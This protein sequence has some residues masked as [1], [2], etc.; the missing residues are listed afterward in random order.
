MGPARAVQI[1]PGEPSKC[2]TT[3]PDFVER[4]N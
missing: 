4:R 3:A 2:D 1:M